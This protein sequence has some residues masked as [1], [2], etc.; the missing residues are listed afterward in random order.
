MNFWPR[1]PGLHAARR[2]S[3]SGG[4]GRLLCRSRSTIGS[5]GHRAAPRVPRGRV[6]PPNARFAHPAR[7]RSQIG[8]GPIL[9]R[10]LREREP[11]PDGEARSGGGHFLGVA[12]PLERKGPPPPG[13]PPVPG[14]PVLP[15]EA[16]FPP[17]PG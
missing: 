5:A 17:F 8:S 16:V 15:G 2:G 4:G 6:G 13:F 11:A 3:G 7:R 9:L 12:F 1:V 14:F 10:A